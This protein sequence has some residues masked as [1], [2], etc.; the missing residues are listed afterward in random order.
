MGVY[1]ARL[2]KRLWGLSFL[3]LPASGGSRPSWTSGCRTIISASV[4]TW[5]P[6]CLSFFSRSHKGTCYWVQGQGRFSWWLRGKEPACQCRRPKRHGFDPWVRK[7]PWRRARQ[8]TPVFLPGEPS[9]QESL[10][11]Y[12]L[13]CH[14]NLDMPE[15]TALMQA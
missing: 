5:P 2:P 10:V 7:I 9:G 1:R 12:R 13:Q 11:G 3:P 6:P 15:A 8:P 14:K 4:F